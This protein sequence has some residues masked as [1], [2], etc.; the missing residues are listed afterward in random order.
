MN[1]RKIAVV[2]GSRAE[3]GLLYWLLHEINEDN[4]L[5]LMLIVTGMHLSADFGSTYKEIE[6]DGFH[7]A[8]KVDI[9]SQEDTPEAVAYSTGQGLLQFT[10]TLNRLKPDILV[11]LGDRYEILSAALA[12]MFL[13]IPIAH[14]HGGELTVGAVDDAIRHVVTKMSHYHFVATEPYQK[15][16]IQMGEDPSR[17]F[18]F[19]A[20]GLDHISRSELFSKAE[21]EKGLDFQFGK[22]NFLVTFHPVTRE[23]D[24]PEEAVKELLSAL[25]EFPEAKIIFTKSNADSGGRLIGELIDEY[26]KKNPGRSN[27]FTSLG[28]QKYLSAAKYVDVVIGNS[29]SGLIE[30]PVV[31]TP[32]VN[33]GDRQQGRLLAS[34]V[35]CCDVGKNSIID[36][37]N[38]ALSDEF[39][40]RLPRIDCPYGQGDA[41]Y[42]I[43]E[44]LKSCSLDVLK[45]EFFDR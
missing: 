15:R 38:K 39:Q 16:V 27:V 24:G 18:N 20:P 2:T 9:L 1:K 33:I 36:A 42:K 22:I 29:S 37:V 34:S 40:H 21:F 19:G 43:K 17:V 28:I 26:V 44:I 35:V 7:I 25:D 45:K 23:I 11:V 6:K 41:S 12:A 14:I 10:E 13:N 31:G 30:V 8:A 32:T 4:D 3:Y 5:E